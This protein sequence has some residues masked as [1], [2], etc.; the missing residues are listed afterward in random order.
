MNRSLKFRIW[1]E[2]LQKFHYWGFIENGQTI[3]FWPPDPLG[4][5]QEYQARSEQFTGYSDRNKQEAYECDRVRFC[6]NLFKR[7]ET[8][9]GLITWYHGGFMVLAE[10]RYYDLHDLDFEVIG[11]IHQKEG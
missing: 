9:T 8:I 3:T 10:N 2:Q 7:N 6:P 5:I 1:I 4:S 11:H